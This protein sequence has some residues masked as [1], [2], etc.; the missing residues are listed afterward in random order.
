MPYRANLY[1]VTIGDAW[2]HKH[3][4]NY[5]LCSSCRRTETSGCREARTISISG[6]YGRDG[7]K[8]WSTC[9][10]HYNAVR[11]TMRAYRN[12]LKELVGAWRFE[13]QVSCAQGKFQNAK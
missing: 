1:G 3:S 13:L 4:N 5:A 8:S 6:H 7:R 10:S 9:K 12:L 2:T 11:A